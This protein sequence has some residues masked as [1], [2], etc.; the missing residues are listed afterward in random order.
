MRARLAIVAVIDVVSCPTLYGESG[1][2]HGNGGIGFIGQ[3]GP[4]GVVAVESVFGFRILYIDTVMG[5][6]Q[7]EAIDAVFGFEDVVARTVLGFFL[8]GKEMRMLGL[9]RSH[10]FGNG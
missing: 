5:T 6:V 2:G 9:E 3:L 7:L 1:V 8:N 10:T 4:A